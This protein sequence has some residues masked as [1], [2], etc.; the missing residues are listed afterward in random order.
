MLKQF[1]FAFLLGFAV[2][3]PAGAVSVRPLPLDEIIDTAT[4]VFQGTCIGNR[5]EREQETNLVVTFTTFAVKDVLKGSA[6]GTHVIKQIGGKMPAGELN[7]RVDGVP[8]FVVGEDYVVFLAGVS[9]AGFSSPIG[10]A[11]GKFTV[12]QDAS[13]QKVSNG[14]D[15]RE[16]TAGIPS[17]VLPKATAKVLGE[18][19]A[20]VRHLDLDEFKQLV[21]VRAGRTK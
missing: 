2:A 3:G 20:P 21:R 11:Q 19:P 16:M 4:V 8:T 1:F 5:T 6:Q 10:L 17:V 12:Q 9:A 18:A 15:F 14:R 7:F 13:G